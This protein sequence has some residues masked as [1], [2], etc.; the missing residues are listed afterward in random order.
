MYVHNL[1]FSQ[2]LEFEIVK[3]KMKHIEIVGVSKYTHL[4][5]CRSRI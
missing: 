3:S 5:D 2:I 1:E 4:L